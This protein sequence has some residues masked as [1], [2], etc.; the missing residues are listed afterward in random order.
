MLS[1][2]EA[3]EFLLHFQPKYN[4]AE[5]RVT[6][7]ECLIRWE[8]PGS[9]LVSPGEFIPVAEESNLMI[10][11]GNWII[12]EACRQLR[13]WDDAGLPPLRAAINLSARQFQQGKE[14]LA[15]IDR[16]LER[17]ELSPERL[18]M[19]ITESAIMR[20]MEQTIDLL[21]QMRK[22]G[23]HLSIDDF[24]TG[25]ASLS[26]LKRFPVQALKI[27]QS[28]IRDIG[29]DAQ[30][31]AIVSAIISMGHSLGLSVVAEGVETQTH[32]AFL[33]SKGC[34]HIQGYFYSRPLGAA[35]FEDFVRGEA[36]MPEG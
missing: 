28:F 10:P 15:A 12:G 17:H 25:H 31:E 11:I 19:E 18:E 30:D 35:D 14:L 22:R 34:D 21:E 9:G 8:R 33:R 24:G 32:L 36:E 4:V 7:L 13:V 1:A 5:E 2:L 3:E 16:G 23:L 20:D 29:Q 26:Y 27:D 6:S